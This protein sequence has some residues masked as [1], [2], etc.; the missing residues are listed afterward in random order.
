MTIDPATGVI[1][2]TS[3]EAVVNSFVT[4][5]GALIQ[6]ANGGKL[7]GNAPQGGTDPVL[8]REA[9]IKLPKKERDQRFQE[10]RQHYLK[11]R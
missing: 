10:M 11:T 7:P 3:L 6:S 5:H 9:W 1:D 2:E 8:T 4:T